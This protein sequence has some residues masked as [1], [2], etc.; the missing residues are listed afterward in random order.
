MKTE[1]KFEIRKQS[2]GIYLNHKRNIS[3]DRVH[4]NTYCKL[5]IFILVL[6]RGRAEGGEACMILSHFLRT[7]LTY[8]LLELV[9][10]YKK[11]CSL[12]YNK[13]FLPIFL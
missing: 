6:V 3:D 9:N 2:E 13:F 7:P 4:P 12:D 8:S 1:F 11:E 10:S 5:D